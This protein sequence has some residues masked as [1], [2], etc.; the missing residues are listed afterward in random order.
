LLLHALQEEECIHEV[1]RLSS[2]IVN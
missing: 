1:A 2:I